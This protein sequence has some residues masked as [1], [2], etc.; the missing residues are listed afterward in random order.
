MKFITEKDL[1]YAFV[2]MMNKLIFGNQIVL[3]P[4][5]LSLRSINSEDY[6]KKIQELDKRLDENAEQRKVLVSLMTKGYLEPAVYNKSN[7]EL[8]QDAE[9]LR[10][11]KE[12]LVRFINSDTQSLCEVN[13][14]LHLTTKA[15]MLHGF[16][17]DIF[18]RFVERVIVHSRT[19]V[20]FKLKCGI[21][22]RE[23]LV[24]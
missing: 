4:L 24:K 13:E 9:R 14:L 21:T 18:N 22:L 2:T 8:I 7:N 3:R 12:S 5:L 11:Q 10:H 6:T 20:G 17:G 15:K 1:E 23:R 19:E 16:D